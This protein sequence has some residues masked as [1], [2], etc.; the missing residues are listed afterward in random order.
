MSGIKLLPVANAFTAGTNFCARHQN[1]ST[2][3]TK[4]IPGSKLIYCMDSLHIQD[5]GSIS[6]LRNSHPDQEGMK[7][8]LTGKNCDKIELPS[9]SDKFFFRNHHF[10]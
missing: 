1:S 6:I 8:P 3:G 5:A 2:A 4:I 10:C 7:G 9:S